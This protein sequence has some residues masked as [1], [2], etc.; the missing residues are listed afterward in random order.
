MSDGRQKVLITGSK[1]LI[2]HWIAH[3]SSSLHE[4]ILS[5]RDPEA[6]HYLDLSDPNSIHNILN[7][8]CPNTIVNCAGITSI[9]SAAGDPSLSQSVNTESVAL[10]SRWCSTNNARLIHFSTDFVFDGKA[11]FYNEDSETIPQSIY[12]A[13]KLNSEKAALT[14]NR[15]TAVVR[16]SLVYG[17]HP[18]LSR[19]NF[20]LFIKQVL[21]KGESLNITADQFR[22]PTY[23]EDLA[24]ATVQLMRSDFTGLLHLAGPQR[25]SVM[26]FA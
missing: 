8:V 20:P 3:Y 13:T 14:N 2:G 16:T 7:K 19:L 15:N 1:G 10:I 23:V 4:T 21:E 25:I 22:S 26:Q 18:E 6:L 17:Y 9:A 11:S 12:G 5:T 24:T